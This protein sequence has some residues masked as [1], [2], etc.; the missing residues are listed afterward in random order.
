MNDLV[1]HVYNECHSD[2]NEL[3]HARNRTTMLFA[4]TDVLRHNG[5]SHNGVSGG[6]CI[7]ILESLEK[8]LNHDD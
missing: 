6:I 1:M 4:V 8:E 3:E 5:I 7:L 2:F